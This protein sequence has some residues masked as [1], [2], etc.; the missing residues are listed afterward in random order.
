MTLDEAIKHCIEKAEEQEYVSKIIVELGREESEK[1]HKAACDECA[2]E[3]R[4]FAE[5]LTELKEAK[6]LLKVAV[7]DIHELLLDRK[8]IR[9]S[10][11]G[12]N[13]CNYI[14]HCNCCESCTVIDELKVWRYADEALK[15]IGGSE[16]DT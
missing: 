10:G 16:N 11:Q 8:D 12:C 15:L 5:W 13:V 7:E 2:A 9:H 14:E 3:H 4:Q 1:E 6:R